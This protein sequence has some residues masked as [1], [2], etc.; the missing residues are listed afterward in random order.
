MDFFRQL[1]HAIAWRIKIFQNALAGMV[2]SDAVQVRSG[3][4]EKIYAV[5]VKKLDS[6]FRPKVID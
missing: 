5:A 6:L 2:R 4:L 1:S 3:V